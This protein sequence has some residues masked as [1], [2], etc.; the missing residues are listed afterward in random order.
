MRRHLLW[1]AA[2]AVATGLLIGL[3]VLG[4]V[5]CVA[6]L[7]LSAGLGLLTLVASTATGLLALAASAAGQHYRMR[8]SAARGVR[9]TEAWLERSQGRAE[10]AG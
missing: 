3:A 6:A 5:V 2:R 7:R 1:P 8:V 10:G 9:E 4:A